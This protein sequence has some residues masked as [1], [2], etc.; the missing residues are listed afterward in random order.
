MEDRIIRDIAEGNG[1]VV[2]VILDGELECVLFVFKAANNIRVR[3][4]DNRNCTDG[5]KPFQNILFRMLD[6]RLEVRLC[7]NK[8]DLR[9][10]GVR[11]LSSS[12]KFPFSLF[13][14]FPFSGVVSNAYLCS[15]CI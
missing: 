7:G 9:P 15:F 12:T 11:S 3:P 5:D 10:L 6:Y 1:E 14:I 4:A 13:D 2:T 8:M